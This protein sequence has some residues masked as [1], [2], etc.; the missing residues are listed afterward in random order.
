MALTPATVRLDLKCG[1]GAIS[2]GEKCHVGT[3][4]K[5]K[6]NEPTFSNRLSAGIMGAASLYTGG[7]GLVNLG[8]AVQNKSGGNAIAGVGQLLGAGLGLRA[9]S[10]YLKGRKLSGDLHTLGAVGLS[11]GGEAV[12]GAVAESEFRRRQANAVVNKPY[13]GP[14]PY[15]ALGIGKNASVREARAAYMKV[16]AQHHPDRGGDVTK[17]RAAKQAYE[18][19]LRRNN[20]RRDSV[21][22]SGFAP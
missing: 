16:A 19:L 3:A 2:E 1:N 13:D 10:E 21:W 6:K 11:Q 15:K 7:V 20:G 22:A 4:S 8:A 14:D 17:F 18:E 9:S 5:A 12:G